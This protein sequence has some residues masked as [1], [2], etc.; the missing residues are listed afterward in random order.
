MRII[1]K[2]QIAFLALVLLASGF[3]IAEQSTGL[4][5]LSEHVFAYVDIKNASPSGN[6]FGA[7]SGV[8][9]GNDAVLVIDT[10]VSAKQA[11]ELIADIK[12][13]TDKP[14]KYVVNT[15][16]HLD[17]S[18]G[19]C[20]FVK[21]GA[22]VIGQENSRLTAAKIK[23]SLENPQMG[24]MTKQDFEGT[25]A[26]L[27]TITFKDAMQIDLGGVT[28]SLS[29]AG[30]SHTNDSITVMVDQD[31]VLFTGDILFTKY[32]PFIGEGDFANWEKILAG[33]EKTTAKIIVPGHGPVSTVADIRDMEV[34]IT[35]FDKQAKALC[36]GKTQD[37]APA[38]AAELSKTLPDQKRNEMTALI[39]MNLRTRYLPPKK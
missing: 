3:A 5:K 1:S 27:P 9:I 21:L 12:K 6:G 29:Y 14:V 24:G 36:A 15:H 11:Q 22:V 4:T 7:N 31:G 8:V 19:N 25:T 33:L 17:H 13:V 16:Y 18:G 23:E 32:Q 38:I 26:S 30:P 20:E 35:Q 10:R 37:D 39:E 34:Y 2:I 28:V